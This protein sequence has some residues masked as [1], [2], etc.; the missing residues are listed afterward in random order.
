MRRLSAAIGR[1]VTFA[2]LQVDAAPD[3]WREL[4]DASLAAVADGADLWPQVAGPADRPAVRPLHHATAC[5]TSIPA[6]QR[7]QGQGPRPDEFVAALRDPAVRGSIVSWEPD[8]GTRG[9]GWR[10]RYDHT[11]VLG[12]PPDYEPG[13]ERS[14]AGD[15]RGDRAAA[16]RGRLRRDARGRRAAACCT[17]PILNYSDGDLDPVRE[18]LLHPRAAL[19]LA[20]GGAH[21]GVICDASMP[22]FMLTHWT[23]D[24]TRGERLPAR[25]GRQEADPR[26]RPPVRP[27]RPRHDRA[28]HA[29]RPQRHRLRAPAARR[30]VRRGR[31]ARRRAPAGPAVHRLRSTVKS[32]VVTFEDGEETGARPGT[33]P[34]RRAAEYRPRT[35]RCTRCSRFPPNRLA[36]RPPK[37]RGPRRPP[38]RGPRRGRETSQSPVMVSAVADQAK[39]TDA[40]DGVHAV[41]V[42]GGAAHDPQ[43][44]RRR[45]PRPGDLPQGLPGVRQLPGG[46][47]P[48]GV[49]LPD[50]HQHLH[51]LLPV[52]EAPARADRAR[53]RRGPLP[54]P[55][56]GRPGG[57]PPPAA[58]PRTR[59]STCSPRG[60]S[61]TPSRPCPSSSGWPSCL[62]TSRGSRTRRSPTSWTFRS[63]RS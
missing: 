13:P 20:D 54:V 52:E 11:F 47:Q 18:M 41:A 22:T 48:Q 14:L 39:F 59:S 26:H 5:S 60:R 1:P 24:R 27:G 17:C 51:Q 25:V 37:A 56:S 10:R 42:L 32:G 15:R 43:P 45:G 38:V 19:G 31:P 36:V 35:A 4:M 40:G 62:P 46:H 3:L 34:P 55:P 30:A 8:A 12:D 49:A 63:E 21:C 2:L 57:A 23:R 7:A 50:P 16:A 58:A 33:T 6:Y 53:R 28:G 9:A 61:R 44:R 29:G